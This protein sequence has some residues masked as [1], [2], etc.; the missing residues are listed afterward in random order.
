MKDRLGQDTETQDQLN[1]LS[2]AVCVYTQT[3]HWFSKRFSN[4]FNFCIIYFSLRKGL[5]W[6]VPLDII[7]N[8]LHSAWNSLLPAVCVDSFLPPLCVKSFL[9]AVWV[10]SLLIELKTITDSKIFYLQSHILFHSFT[11]FRLLSNWKTAV[12]YY[13]YN[14]I[15]TTNCEKQQQNQR[16][17]CTGRLQ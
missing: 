5:L 4:S 10:N 16:P 15:D 7:R 2:W 6:R 14:F 12:Y 8:Y 3:I 13:Y 17:T 1:V 9:P 11:H